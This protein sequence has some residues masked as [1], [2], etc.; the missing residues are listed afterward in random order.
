MQKVGKI[1]LRAY[2]KRIEN[3]PA[4]NK[5]NKGQQ[6]RQQRRRAEIAVE[7]AEE[8]AEINAAESIKSTALKQSVPLAAES[9]QMPKQAPLRQ[10]PAGSKTLKT[11]I[12]AAKEL[13]EWRFL[14]L[15][16]LHRSNAAKRGVRTE[17]SL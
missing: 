5:I 7:K 4:Q 12:K 13:W 8:N 17:K 1:I 14:C 2:G 9:M 6:K 16:L 11:R 10:T 3:K 15:C